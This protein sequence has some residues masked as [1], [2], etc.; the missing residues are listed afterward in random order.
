MWGGI[1]AGTLLQLNNL[2]SAVYFSQVLS[3]S[4]VYGSLGAVPVMMI[5]LYFSWMIVLYGVEVAHVVAS[6][7]TESVPLPEGELARARIV[8]ETAR[9][10][11]ATFLSG[12]GGLTRREI[13]DALRMP[14]E[15]VGFALQVLCDAGL[16]AATGDADGVGEARYLPARPPGQ[17]AVLDVLM[18]ERK[19][20]KDSSSLPQVTPEVAEFLTR[21]E[22][23]ERSELG[24]V[25]LE[26]LT[27]KRGGAE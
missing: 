24:R 25:T 6:P 23:V 19:P 26:E 14:A 18:A 3:Y 2:V 16:F 20:A 27:R 22:A 10:A 15:W 1:T 17:I 9:V 12:G 11:V 5:G 4:K 8:L 21:L 13:A 7:T